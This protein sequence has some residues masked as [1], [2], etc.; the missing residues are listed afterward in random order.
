MK[1]YLKLYFMLL[2]IGFISL[3]TYRTNFFNNALSSIL[4]SSLTIATM[5][6]LTARTSTVFGWTRQELLLL[7]GIYNIVFGIIY[8]VFASN[9]EELSQLIN[10]GELDSWLL[11]PI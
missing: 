8:A 10:K 4:W 2:R 3:L 11:K 5:V 7:T 9:F 1:R 6:I